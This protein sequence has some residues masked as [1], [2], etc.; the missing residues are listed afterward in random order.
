MTSPSLSCL[1]WPLIPFKKCSYIGSLI[2]AIREILN[3]PGAYPAVSSDFRSNRSVPPRQQ[4][5]AFA[6]AGGLKSVNKAR[7]GVVIYIAGRVIGIMEKKMET[8]IILGL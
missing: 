8:T 1:D 4:Q 7:G 5:A 6:S 3:I 2:K